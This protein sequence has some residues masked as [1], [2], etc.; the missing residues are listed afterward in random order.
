MVLS[1]F[2]FYALLLAVLLIPNIYRLKFANNI[3]YD[4]IE[5]EN[6][7]NNEIFIERKNSKCINK[8]TNIEEKFDYDFKLIEA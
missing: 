2:I 7:I 3:D 5:K 6:E 8:T 1:Y 4:K